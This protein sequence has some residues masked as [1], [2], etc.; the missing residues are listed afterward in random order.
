MKEASLLIVG[1]FAFAAGDAN[2]ENPKPPGMEGQATLQ[3]E[4]LSNGEV[5]ANFDIALSNATGKNI[6]V[7][8]SAIPGAA[9][10]SAAAIEFRGPGGK[11]SPVEAGGMLDMHPV[12]SGNSGSLIV[13]FKGAK[14]RAGVRI[15]RDQYVF[16]NVGL[17][18]AQLQIDLFDCSKL[19]QLSH[20]SESVRGWFVGS[21]TVSASAVLR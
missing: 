12:M 1:A 7:K 8:Y 19:G 16:K 18:S 15:F 9:E 21:L 11:L 6:C 5:A 17:Y 4:R 14:V 20:L 10:F 3:F 2:A 13:V